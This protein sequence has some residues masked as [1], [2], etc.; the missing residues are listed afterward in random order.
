MRRTL[1][2][3]L[4][5]LLVPALLVTGLLATGLAGCA[6]DE[7]ASDDGPSRTAPGTGH[8]AYTEV[9]LVSRS[10]VGGEVDRRP[11]VLD[12]AQDVERFAAQFRTRAMRA[13]VSGAVARSDVPDG[14][15]LV[16]AVVA[17]GCDVPSGV[18]VRGE[19]DS[20]EIVPLEPATTHP[21]CLVAVTTVA[22]VS[23]DSAMLAG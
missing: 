8:V 11:T 9:R 7:V 14:R 21:E 20:L 22:L 18:R 10:A 12:D 4:P 17:L 3:F 19:G 23:I 1:G 15:T 13:E 6:D 2:P 16:G 5:A